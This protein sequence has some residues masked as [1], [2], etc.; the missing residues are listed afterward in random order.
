MNTKCNIN[1]SFLVFP[2]DYWLKTED[3]YKLQLRSQTYSSYYL[4]YFRKNV[5]FFLPLEVGSIFKIKALGFVDLLN[6]N[7]FSSPFISSL[8]LQTETDILNFFFVVYFFTNLWQLRIKMEAFFSE[9]LYDGWFISAVL[10]YSKSLSN[11]YLIYLNSYFG[12]QT[13]PNQNKAS[14]VWYLSQSQLWMICCTI[15]LRHFLKQSLC[16]WVW[17]IMM[18]IWC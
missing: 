15:F 11:F 17:T 6:R 1:L 7:A 10:N 18:M 16:G 14:E 8:I 4:C 13:P 2:V 12:R 9:V 3:F 5:N